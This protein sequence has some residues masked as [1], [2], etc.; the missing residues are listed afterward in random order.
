MPKKPK[1]A[2]KKKAAALPAPAV[3]AAPLA[4]V[5][6]AFGAG[7]TAFGPGSPLRPTVVASAAGRSSPR[8]DGSPPGAALGRKIRFGNVEYMRYGKAM[9]DP[10]CTTAMDQ[11]LN[12]RK[13]RAESDTK[14]MMTPAEIFAE[15]ANDPTW[16][17][18]AMNTE[19]RGCNISLK[20]RGS[21]DAATYKKH[22]GDLI[23]NYTI[24]LRNFAKSGQP[25]NNGEKDWN[26]FVDTA[27]E[28]A[29]PGAPSAGV[30]ETRLKFLYYCLDGSSLASRFC[31]TVP[32]G[33]G[34]ETFD[35]E[36]AAGDPAAD[37]GAA[38]YSRKR[39]AAAEARRKKKLREQES[40]PESADAA[41]IEA[42]AVEKSAANTAMLECCKTAK[43]MGCFDSDMAAL[44]K[45]NT[46]EALKGCLR[47]KNV[48]TVD[49]DDVHIDDL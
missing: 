26:G 23:G 30:E 27:M 31:R 44:L 18:V 24:L 4:N 17:P 49:G 11:L 42:R 1:A 10:S 9:V 46:M 19:V 21:F 12:G 6:A 8:L 41:L 48:F 15:K 38:E 28:E 36:D 33:T 34:V 37:C 47:D 43:D 25:G 7:G 29:Y 39:K 2:A 40:S 3:S 20:F 35:W 5:D 32:E 14:Q 13:E 45:K 22:F 16:E